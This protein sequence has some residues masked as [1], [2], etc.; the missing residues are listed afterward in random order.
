M[1]DTLL[2]EDRNPNSLEIDLKST[3]EIL[4]MINREDQIVASTVAQEISHIVKAVDL[5]VA[6]FH[7]GD[8]CFMLG[9]E[10]AVVWAC[11]MQVNARRLLTSA[12]C[13]FKESLQEV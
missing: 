11:L 7:K 9:P 6:A 12:L 10:Q 1:S 4:R 3:E 2:T 5:I 8:D 13:G